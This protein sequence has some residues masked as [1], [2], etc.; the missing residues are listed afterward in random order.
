M[1][2]DDV[3]EKVAGM[4]PELLRDLEDLTR[5]ASVAFPGYPPEPVRQMADR[6]VEVMRDA[7]FHNAEL[8]AVPDGY[9]PIYATVPGPRGRTHRAAVRPLRRPASPSRTGLVV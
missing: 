8:Q 7:G 6:T 3:R 5:L 2:R 1:N 4:M 9:P